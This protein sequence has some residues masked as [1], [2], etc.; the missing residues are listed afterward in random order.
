MPWD[1]NLDEQSPAYGIAADGG[2]RVRTIAGPGTGKSFSMRRRVARL[3][4]QGVDPSRI[5]AITFTRIAAEDIRRELHGLGIA[6][7]EKIEARTLHSLAMRMLSRRH[8]I[9]LLG[10]HTR[11]M[12][13]FETNPLLYDLSDEFGT[14]RQRQDRVKEYEAAFAT[15]Q[16][17]DPLNCA[18]DKDR[19]FRAELVDWLTFHRCML[20]GELIPFMYTYLR[21]NPAAREFANYD[22]ILVDEYQ[23]LNKVEQSSLN[24]L[25]RDCH[26]IIVGDDNQSIYSFK[27]AH[28][29]GITEWED[30]NPGRSEHALIDCYRCPER[31]VSMANSLIAHNAQG[32]ARPLAALPH[33]GV[34]EASLVQFKTSDDEADG[35]AASI[36]Q[37]VAAG[38]RP[39]DI[40]VLTPRKKL[41]MKIADR[42][43]EAAI[44]CR[45]YLSESQLETD[46]VTERLALLMVASDQDDRPALRWLLGYGSADFRAGQYKRLRQFCEIENLSPW[47]ALADIDAGRRQLGRCRTLMERFAQIRDRIAALV[48][49]GGAQEIVDELFPAD[50]PEFERMRELVAAEITAETE[51]HEVASLIL[52][53]IYEPDFPA[54]ADYVRVMTLYGSKGLGTP[55]VYLT[56]LVD[57]L[58][59]RFDDPQDNAVERQ[60]KR[61]EQRRLFYVALTRVKVDRARG[62]PGELIMSN[63]TQYGYDEAHTLNNGN[64]TALSSRFL[65]ELGERAPK[66]VR[67]N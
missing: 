28:P 40:L 19:N 38:V 32:L 33:N 36:V 52:E 43:R 30:G 61:E 58:V 12:G 23:D 64:V 31:V 63:F 24:I 57:G 5:L 34:G 18:D 11:P 26:M 8:V 60:R 6:G 41:G 45:E 50:E 46:D 29:D 3:I 65:T 15:H 44:P 56:S 67:G 16:D 66:A 62:L 22:H 35:I 55:V 47:E 9:Q 17:D 54:D 48:E 10:R 20:I 4:E 59:P 2:R 37:K 21:D 25:G 27:Y 14:K 13:N 42:L 51:L 49:L 7:S 39:E 53:K 1:D